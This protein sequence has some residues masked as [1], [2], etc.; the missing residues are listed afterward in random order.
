MKIQ[1]KRS[2]VLDGGVAK[3]PTADQMEF[4]ELAINYNTGDPSI[5]LKDSAGNIVKSDLNFDS[6][7]FVKVIGDNM[8][9]NLTL[10]TDKIT[11]DASDGSAEFVG[12]VQAG[13]NPQG[14]ANEG[15]KL[16]SNGSINATRT[17]GDF[18]IW[19]GYTTGNSTSTSSIL[20]DGSAS[21]SGG[22]DALGFWASKDTKDGYINV[23][24][25]V[26]GQ[27]AFNVIDGTGGAT[28]TINGDGGAEFGNSPV[29]FSFT[30][31]Y[32]G[33]IDLTKD[34]NSKFSVDT[35]GNIAASGNST[36]GGS[37]SFVGAI[38]GKGVGPAYAF[39]VTDGITNM[40][41]LYRDSNGANLYLK[42]SAGD[43][44]AA[45]S[46]SSDGSA[47][48]AGAVTSGDIN[49]ASGSTTGVQLFNQGQILV[50]RS[51]TNLV[52]GAYNGT[53]KTIDF[54]STGSATFNARVTAGVSTLT[55]KAIEALNDTRTGNGAT[56]HA[57]QYNSGGE[58]WNGFSNNTQTSTIYANGNATFAGTVVSDGG[59]EASRTGGTS[60]VFRGQ[61]GS[62]A[63]TSTILADG[64]ATFS[65]VVESPNY[66]ATQDTGNSSVFRGRLDSN[67]NVF[68]TL[69]YGDGRATFASTITAGGYSMA[70]LAQL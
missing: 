46:L 31:G 28:A 22:V 8:T 36:F 45:V 38:Q 62:G 69:I 29:N 24:Q 53:T 20:A 13:G 33:G 52:F 26:G 18:N 5:F 48:F 63:F 67:L 41:G 11:L 42:N 58:V 65:G 4:G 44:P 7:A 56:V 17:R 21:F 12:D 10:G 49:A 6:S 57:F 32:A 68:T 60:H 39:E 3:A 27:A 34:G 54:Q 2:S 14:G 40:G 43:N 51:S 47:S 30:P 55:D 61:T 37:A 59:Y 70:S 9:G 1:L 64:T 50:Q 23:T 19:T 66:T 16:F 25:Q 35:S 15:S